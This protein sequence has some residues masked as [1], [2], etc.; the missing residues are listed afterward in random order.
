MPG[1][2]KFTIYGK[3]DAIRARTKIN[4]EC[5]IFGFVNRYSVLLSNATVK[6]CRETL[7]EYGVSSDNIHEMIR[8]ANT[9]DL[10][11]MK[12]VD[13]IWAFHIHAPFLI[14]PF[15]ESLLFEKASCG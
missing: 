4:T 14:I 2:H 8:E 12:E 6:A 9:T 13:G 10:N 1:R 7:I 5:K 15:K 3:E 11:A